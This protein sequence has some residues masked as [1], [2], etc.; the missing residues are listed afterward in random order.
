M[1]PRRIAL[2]GFLCYRAE[3]VIDFDG[4][5]LWVLSGRNGSGKS[6]VFDA[7]TF[8][9]FGAHRGGQR[10]AVKLINADSPG[11]EVT[12][13]FD[14]GGD[15]YRIQRSLR[16]D[17][18]GLRLIYR[19]EAGEGGEAH[20]LPVPETDSK[21]G[22]DAWVQEHLGLTYETFT[23]SVLLV[24]GQA[25]KLLGADHKER[26]NV[27]AGVE[28][29]ARFERLGKKAEA[30]RVAAKAHADVL[31]AQVHALSPVDE[32]AV[33][34]AVRLAAAAE[35]A[36]AAAAA[37]LARRAEIRQRA[38]EW[39]DLDAQGAEQRREADEANA[40]L[41]NAEEIRRDCA[42]LR[43]LEDVLPAVRDARDRR[44]RLG[45]A[46][47]TIGRLD[48][49]R[50][51]LARALD[52]T[53]A[54]VAEEE[55]HRAAIVQEIGRDESRL[56]AVVERL[57]ALA[58]PLDRARRAR[59]GREAAGRIEV[60][61]A[62]DPV[63]S[64]AEVERL[65]G[66]HLR[67]SDW[68]AAFSTLEGFA[69]DRAALASARER[70][71]SAR[72]A[73]EGA[74]AE[75]VALSAA[76][77]ALLAE[78]ALAR[79]AAEAARDRATGARTVLERAADS[80]QRFL[81]LDGSAACDRCGQRLTPAHFAA[82]SARL[83]DEE[84]EAR[85]LAEE[86]DRAYRVAQTARR[87]AE[88]AGREAVLRGQDARGCVKDHRHR[89]DQ[90]EGDAAR[91]DESCARASRAL[92]E[93]FRDRVA[94]APPVDWV[95]TVFP[96][97][98]DLDDARLLV[99]EIGTIVQQR[100][101][102]RRRQDARQVLLIRR[103]E[104]LRAAAELG[105]DADAEK[106][107]VAEQ[108]ALAAEREAI[109][110]CLAAHEAALALAEETLDRLGERSRDL[111]G[112]LAAIDRDL[113][114]ERAC[115][116]GFRAEWERIRAGAP[117]AWRD[118]IDGASAADIEGWEAERRTLRERQVE[119]R[120]GE[121][122]R[123]QF[124]LQAAQTRLEAL[125]R[126][127]EAIPA[128][129]RRDRSEID[130][131]VAEAQRQLDTAE[132]IRREAVD[133]RG[134]LVREWEFRRSLEVQARVAERELS[135]SETLARLL[136]WNGL[137][138]H[139]LR[140]AEQSIL[141]CTNRFLRVISGGDLELQLVEEG[142]S[143]RALHM[144]AK[145]RTHGGT[146]TV[147]PVYL[148]GSQKFRVAVSLALGIGQ[149]ARGAGRRIETVIIDEGF[150]CLD[151]QGRQEMI[152][153]LGDLQGVLAR[154]ILVSHQEEVAEAFKDG[155]RFEVID[156]ATVVEPFHR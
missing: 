60:E 143:E 132:A 22:F 33:E 141:A 126:R 35:A 106:T 54:L 65:E 72:A 152:A 62:A 18:A 37:E 92:P 31:R 98:S 146:R 110:R 107:L 79:E 150:G 24:Q 50:Q 64:S 26:Y 38:R 6:A 117:D 80:F 103:D 155:Y 101:E 84:A 44:I 40:L 4:A 16:R 114:A 41:A 70:A 19:H 156:G 57:S 17:R 96:T 45:E 25:E 34:E 30:R 87:A 127:I 77:E 12:F 66:E 75:S 42:R 56:R 49:E 153:Q 138:R 99:A 52:Q 113:S 104:A 94:P 140:E 53:D 32:A 85:R 23:S 137:Q 93:S 123:A 151:R 27:L 3:Q 119:A 68:R 95:A 88:E 69:R 148:S 48:A 115:A 122:P 39:A 131:S 89:L 29:L 118:A 91:S 112:R 90:A 124:R 21:A 108:T 2:K 55:T 59:E 121:L 128:E 136:G 20:W 63:A 11:F 76:C 145:V 134:Q 15:R 154:I 135:I 144:E 46:E 61:L 28:D 1:I 43:A 5:D 109:S 36:R 8:A 58:V 100:D 147:E 71:R 14:L 7:L 81:D 133:R 142:D 47:G 129:A 83:R 149:H 139:R 73:L 105:V 78:D 116:G 13:D 9:L 74:E 130:P 120:V 82:E 86:A 10:S 97:A 125:G 102:A 51:E 67:R 111:Q